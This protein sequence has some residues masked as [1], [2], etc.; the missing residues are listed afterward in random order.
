MTGVILAVLQRLPHIIVRSL[1]TEI[2]RI[3]H[4]HGLWASWSLLALAASIPLFPA[5]LPILLIMSVVALAVHHRIW[6]GRETLTGAWDRVMW[7][8]VALYVLYVIGL[9]WSSNFDYA[10]F[11]LQIKLPLA[12]LSLLFLRMPL[13]SRQ[14]GD[15][16]I[17][18]FV[19]GN[20]IAVVLCCA[21][22]PVH[23]LY[24]GLAWAVAVFGSDFSF[25]LHPSYFALYLCFSLSALLLTPSPL[26]FRRS[27]RI[28]ITA[29]L[30]LGI[31]LCGSKAG[32]ACL[33]VVL[34]IVLAMRWRDRSLRRMIL[35]LLAASV[36]GVALLTA[37]SLN[38]RQR[39]LEAWHAVASPQDH[40]DATTSSEERKLAW[41]GAMEVIR[42]NLPWGTGTGDVKD[43]LVATYARKGYTRLVELRLNAHNQYLQTMATLGWPGILLLLAMLVVPLIVFVRMRDPLAVI[44][45]LLNAINW[46]VE[47]MLE[48]QGGVVFFAFIL[49]VLAIRGSRSLSHDM[50]KP[51]DPA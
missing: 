9:A 28:V 34:L 18:I 42:K 33:P 17:T 31:V 23:V 49:F 46:T 1:K 43:E 41:V 7:G 37:A 48:V 35:A 8:P 36:F 2:A 12:I 20:T 5:A 32:W 40:A 4:V 29:V 45:I 6:K 15:L 25:I 10:S 50:S 38:V 3:Q 30:C 51:N 26:V 24:G 21:M 19:A 16:L 44:F 39:V 22:V 27:S 13:G 14:G 47:S 11:D